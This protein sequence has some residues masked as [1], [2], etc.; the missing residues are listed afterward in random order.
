MMFLDNKSQGFDDIDI[1]DIDAS[2]DINAS[3]DILEMELELL[4][5]MNALTVN[6]MPE[7]EHRLYITLQFELAKAMSPC[8]IWIPWVF[9][10]VLVNIIKNV[11]RFRF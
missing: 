2:D 6:M 7:D 3:D 9:L 5:N 1:D 8:I 11:F 4:N 10:P